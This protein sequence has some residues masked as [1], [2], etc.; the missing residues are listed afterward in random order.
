[1]YCFAIILRFVSTNIII[2]IGILKKVKDARA[3][4]SHSIK[5]NLIIAKAG[6]IE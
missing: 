2:Q 4:I 1:M 3:N 6:R 5:T